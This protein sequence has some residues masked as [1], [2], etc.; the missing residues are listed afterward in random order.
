[1]RRLTAL[2]LVSAPHARLQ[3]AID[4]DAEAEHEHAAAI[5]GGG[6]GGGGGGGG[7]GTDDDGSGRG[8]GGGG[9]GGGAGLTL[10]DRWRSLSGTSS[11]RL[12]APGA[13]LAGIG[14]KRHTLSDAQMGGYA[15][16]C[17]FTRDQLPADT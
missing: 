2:T 10:G 7:G 17:A 14:T 5:G 1:M 9:E 3:A 13:R 11:S 15:G 16:V 6:S 4:A 12:A 8:G